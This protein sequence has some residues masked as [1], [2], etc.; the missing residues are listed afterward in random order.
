MRALRPQVAVR[1]IEGQIREWQ[2]VA[3]PQAHLHALQHALA[4]LRPGR[5]H[6]EE[7]QG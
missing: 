2:A 7:P 4:A 5:G 1:H 6:G 3:V